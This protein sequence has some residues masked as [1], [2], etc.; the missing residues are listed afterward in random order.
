MKN[1]TKQQITQ[2]YDAYLDRATW[3]GK[4]PTPETIKQTHNVLN[5]MIFDMWMEYLV[6]T[7]GIANEVY[8][9]PIEKM[10]EEMGAVG[11]V[12]GFCSYLQGA[13]DVAKEAEEK[14]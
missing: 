4:T 13:I 6:F 10:L 14:K 11:L 9:I 8:E 5:D 12:E 2:A 7:E 3:I 1:Q